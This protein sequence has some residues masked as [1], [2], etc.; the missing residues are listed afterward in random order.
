[1]SASGRRPSVGG[2]SSRQAQR[3]P[4]RHRRRHRCRP[5]AGG[6][7]SRLRD[8]RSGG[9]PGRGCRP[10]SGGIHRGVNWICGQSTLMYGLRRACAPPFTE[11]IG[12]GCAR[13]PSV[14]SWRACE[15]LFIEERRRSYA[16]PTSASTSRRVCASPFM[17]ANSI[18]GRG[19]DLQRV[20][21]CGPP[22]GLEAMAT[23]Q[24]RW[25]RPATFVRA[26]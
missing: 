18:Q 17:E 20:A 1:V 9:R 24:S 13:R 22:F 2:P 6:P 19:G 10:R 26:A 16:S 4:V 11:A 23:A 7:S 21:A 14:G 8:C 25:H 5:R 3:R 12:T 15:L